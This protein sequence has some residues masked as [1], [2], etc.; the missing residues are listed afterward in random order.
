M[1][2]LIKGKHAPSDVMVLPLDLGAGE[3]SL[4]DAVQKAESYF[5][6]AGVDYMFHNAATERPVSVLGHPL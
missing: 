5:G 2:Y 6:G 3:D 4:K 1:L